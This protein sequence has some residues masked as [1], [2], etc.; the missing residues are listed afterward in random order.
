MCPTSH[1]FPRGRYQALCY[2]W[3]SFGW[4]TNICSLLGILNEMK[5]L[6]STALSREKA[7]DLY[8]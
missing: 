4:I 6:S 1:V 5:F 7:Q 8:P 2:S 3:I